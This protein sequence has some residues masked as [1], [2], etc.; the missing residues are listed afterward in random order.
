MQKPVPQ[1]SCSGAVGLDFS[2][3]KHKIPQI[4]LITS[5]VR[6]FK[7]KATKCTLA[8]PVFPRSLLAYDL[9][10]MCFFLEISLT[11][12]EGTARVL[13]VLTS[14]QGGQAGPQMVVWL[15]HNSSWGILALACGLII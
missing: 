13:G 7:S 10:L 2:C 12:K 3:L 11:G 15:R 4:G 1:K 5:T 14:M 8:W 9:P 6:L